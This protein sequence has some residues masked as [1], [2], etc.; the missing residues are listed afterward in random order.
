MYINFLS[1]Y[2][3]EIVTQK[4]RK[5]KIMFFLVLRKEFR[6]HYTPPT[7]LCRK[8]DFN[9]LLLL[10]MYFK[11]KLKNGFYTIYVLFGITDKL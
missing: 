6:I 1:A 5:F 3:F 2:C 11:A 8:I 9:F 10:I 4:Y 7:T